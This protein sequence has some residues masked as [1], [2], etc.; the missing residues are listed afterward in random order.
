MKW[1]LLAVVLGFLMDLCF[2]DPRWLYH[3]ASCPKLFAKCCVKIARI[4]I[5]PP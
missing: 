3:P 2:G 5:I 1:T 4:H